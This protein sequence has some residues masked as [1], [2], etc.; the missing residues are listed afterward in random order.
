MAAI[1]TVQHVSQLVHKKIKPSSHDAVAISKDQRTKH[2][3]ILSR[4]HVSRQGCSEARVWHIADPIYV[5][6][7]EQDMIT[8]R[9]VI[10]DS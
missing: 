10:A 2:E 6:K 3:S 8:G 4:I 1:P 5:L 9:H 7:D